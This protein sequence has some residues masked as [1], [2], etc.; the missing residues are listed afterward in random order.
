MENEEVTAPLHPNDQRLK[1]ERVALWYDW[2]TFN[3][4]VDNDELKKPNTTAP[5]FD[6]KAAW[7]G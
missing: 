6:L 1:E 2:S 4:P 7:T 3:V 5:A